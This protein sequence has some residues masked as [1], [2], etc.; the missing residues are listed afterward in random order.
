[1]IAHQYI[2]RRTGAVKTERLL[3]DGWLR[4]MYG[5]ARE[6]AHTLFKL[7]TSARTSRLLATLNYDVPLGRVGA[8]AFA[9]S[10]GVN[11]SECVDPA[12]DLD[13]PRKIFERRIRYW[14]VRPM[15][16]EPSTVVCPAD[17]RLLVGSLASP[18]RLFLKDKFFA[19]EELLGLHHGGWLEAFRGGDLAIFRL[20]PE[21]YHF[22]HTPVAGVVRDIYELA[23]DY[24]SCNPHAVVTLVTPY[25]KNRRVV[26]VL[27]TDVPG[28]T[29]CG[30][31]AM[32]EVV[33]L[34]IGD[35]IQCYSETAYDAPRAVVTGLFVRK[36]QPKSLYRPGSSTDVLLFQR[37]RVAFSDDLLRNTARTDAHSRFTEGFG[38]PLVETEVTVRSTIATAL[39]GDCHDG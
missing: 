24:H 2:D 19:F 13:T 16:D 18:S 33:A 15:D 37:G 11:L 3:A 22:S 38:Q 35:V 39:G 25:S 21:K 32:I 7:L 5:P 20:T 23:G 27:D 9:R 29:G 4:L 10:L 14:D 34:M 28:G 1:M 6:H 30:L 36:G 12:D 8:P 26:T 17:A 31:V